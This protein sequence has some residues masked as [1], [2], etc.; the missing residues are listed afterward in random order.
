M[1]DLSNMQLEDESLRQLSSYL[2]ENPALRSLGIAQNFFTD[3]G[4]VHLINS[5]KKNQTL[6]HLN[7]QGCSGITDQ[8][9]R[10]MEDLVSEIN[11]SLYSIEVDS[12]G[13]D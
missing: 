7:I 13:F 12:S 11:M 5:L 9:L 4:L 6:N 10:A 1:V 8:S 2:E 3:D